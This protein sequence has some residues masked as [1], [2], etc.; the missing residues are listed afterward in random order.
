MAKLYRFGNRLAGLELKNQ[1]EINRKNPL[2]DSTKYGKLTALGRMVVNPKSAFNKLTP[3]QKDFFVDYYINRLGIKKSMENN[4]NS[5]LANLGP[6]ASTQL[7]K[8]AMKL[9]VQEMYL[10]LGINRKE[11]V[12]VI[13]RGM[14]AKHMIYDRESGEMLEFPDRDD[15]KLQLAAA[16]LALEVL[17]DIGYRHKETPPPAEGEDG[18]KHPSNITINIGESDSIEDAVLQVLS[19]RFGKKSDATVIDITPSDD[20]ISEEK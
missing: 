12:D 15:H 3:R 18:K 11:I 7:S 1:E 17:N 20:S 6:A 9:T 10:E 2:I 14:N 5:S 8:P 13:K 4:F 16:K 19:E